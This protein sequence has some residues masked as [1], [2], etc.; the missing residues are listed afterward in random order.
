MA[1]FDLT[2][3]FKRKN[4]SGQEPIYKVLDSQQFHYRFNYPGSYKS[5]AKLSSA[6]N[7]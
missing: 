6:H 2:I 4:R 3:Y 5:A 1:R 7:L